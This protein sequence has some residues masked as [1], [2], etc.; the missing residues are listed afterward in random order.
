M[1]KRLIAWVLNWD[2]MVKRVLV[3]VDGSTA[4]MEAARLGVGAA[5]LSAGQIKAVYVADVQRLAHLPGYSS[6]PGIKEKLLE[7]MEK[8]G[9]SATGS[10]QHLAEEAG[11]L[12]EGEVLQGDPSQE[13]LRASE[14]WPAELIVLG[15]VGHGGLAKVILGSV[16]EKV[17]RKAKIPVLLVPAKGNDS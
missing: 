1:S 15:R 13:I 17:V 14:E 8:E 7:L 3:A 16:A 11:V 12:Y 10:V 4:S 6:F 5:R 2:N 9:R